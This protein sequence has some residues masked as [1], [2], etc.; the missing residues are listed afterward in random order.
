MRALRF[1]IRDYKCIEDS[2]WVELGAVTALVE[3]NESGKTAALEA[4][5]KF[6]SKPT[7]E[8]ARKDFPRGGSKDYDPSTVCVEVEVEP[9][10]G[11]RETLA[12][13]IP[14]L[15]TM[16]SFAVASNYENKLIFNLPLPA[17]Y[18]E[19]TLAALLPGLEHVLVQL[20]DPEESI[21]L[22]TRVR[23]ESFV[24]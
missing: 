21:H 5:Q 19:P 17:T 7:V 3:K 4:L 1:R 12:A 2:G 6:N 22:E 20:L 15:K 16:K 8:F 10:E 11:E 23:I 14:E 13:I 9:T 24:N 18:Q